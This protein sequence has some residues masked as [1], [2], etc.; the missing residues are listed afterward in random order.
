[1]TLFFSGGEKRKAGVGFIVNSRAIKSVIAFQP[2]S[3]CIAVLTIDS[4]IKTHF[5]SIYAPTEISPDPM[6]DCFYNLLQHTLD[7]IPQTDIIIPTGDFN[8]HI[9]ADRTGWEGTM[10]C[11]SHEK[12]NDSG[13]RLLS[14]ATTNNLLIG[15]SHFQ[16][17]RKHQ[18][19]WRNPSGKDAAV[20]DYVL[21][22]TRF[23]SSVKDVRAMR[24]PDCGSDHYL[25]QSVIKLGLQ[26]AKQK[27]APSTKLDWKRLKDP[28]QKREFQIKLT[29]RFAAL[30][31]S[32]DVDE[33][34]EQIT[35]TIMDSAQP[36]CPPI[37]HRTQ[38]WI[39]NDCLD[40]LDE[41]K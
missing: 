11:F 16:H 1:M 20:L 19:T 34:Q 5:V 41:R 7:I 10:G 37:R 40:L 32:E 36:L 38:P 15:N 29:N 39:S 30:A 14:F 4:T 17:P 24:G 25:V 33:I 26:R 22:N 2:I 31:E 27:S 13:L 18:L 12:I 23:R 28:V 21:I 8:A 35:N 6:K 9:G 3:D